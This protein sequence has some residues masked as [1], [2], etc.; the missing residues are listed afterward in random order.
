MAATGFGVYLVVEGCRVR[1]WMIAADSI[2]FAILD[3]G[4]KV[5]GI[6]NV[7]SGWVGFGCSNQCVFV[8]RGVMLWNS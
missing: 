2:G 4:V 8:D 3:S 7:G 5:F 6:G 1:S